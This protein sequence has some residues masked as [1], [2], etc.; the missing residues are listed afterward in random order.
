MKFK[1]SIF[2]FLLAAS[3]FFNAHAQQ[4]RIGLAPEINLPTGNASSISGVGFGGSVKA[5]IALADKYAITANGGYNLFL[6][7]KKLGTKLENIEAVPVKLGFKHYP[8]P[9][10]YIEGQA[11]AAFHMGASSRTSF[12]WS[13]GFGT[14]FKTGSS[15]NKLEFG[16]RY[17][18]WTNT[19]YGAT[20]TLK[21]TS[22]SFIGL[23]LGYVFGI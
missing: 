1:T 15:N 9:D 17:E 8:S 22:F 18:A 21:T 19:S 5:E 23:K 10:F 6:T 20:S 11:G 2:L 7:K 3:I 13:P 4:V 14:Y 12:V 16:L